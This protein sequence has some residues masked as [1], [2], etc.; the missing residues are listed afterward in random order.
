LTEASAL[1]DL[2][3]HQHFATQRLGQRLETSRD[4]DRIAD[5]RELRM[6]LVSDGPGDRHPRVNADPKSDRLDQRISQCAIEALNS[7]CDC[8]AGGDRLPARDVWRVAHTEQR[9][10]AVTQNLVGL[11]TGA[12]HRAA[13]GVEKLVDDEHGVERQAPFGQPA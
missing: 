2:F 10:Q 6:A 4:I 3:R 8:G 1:V 12:Q 13:H 9:Q 5:H 11:T 7:G